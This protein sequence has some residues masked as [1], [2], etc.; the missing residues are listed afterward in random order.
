MRSDRLLWFGV[1]G[2]PLAWALQLATN[3]TVPEWF[4]CTEGFRAPG[5]I[6][7]LSNNVIVA[8]VSGAAL[9]VAIAALIVSL[10]SLQTAGP[11]P[12]RRERWMA[13]AGVINSV[14]FSLPIALG[15]IPAVLLH[16]CRPSP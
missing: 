9:A 7:G 12:E 2:A 6:F 13:V 4:S 3:E 16:T 5:Q 10:R 14:L 8:L 11:E 1:L 15:F